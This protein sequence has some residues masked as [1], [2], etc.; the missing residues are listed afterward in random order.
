MPRAAAA[1]LEAMKLGAMRLDA[2]RVEVSLA[3][4]DRDDVVIEG[5]VVGAVV[6]AARPVVE[7]VRCQ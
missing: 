3:K 4:G 2:N 1:K 6:G 5:T 7:D